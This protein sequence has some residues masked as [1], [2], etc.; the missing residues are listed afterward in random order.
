MSQ[1]SQEASESLPEESSYS[2]L[3]EWDGGGVI[4]GRFSPP[5]CGLLSIVLGAPSFLA[6]SSPLLG[7]GGDGQSP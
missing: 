4:L 5:P 3:G 6:V 2:G 7:A 1:E